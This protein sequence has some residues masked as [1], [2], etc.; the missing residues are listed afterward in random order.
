MSLIFLK[1]AKD[2]AA[3]DELVNYDQYLNPSESRFFWADSGRWSEHW[4]LGRRVAYLLSEAI[5]GK[6]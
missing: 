3:E 5:T 4:I 6:F 2:E 1:T